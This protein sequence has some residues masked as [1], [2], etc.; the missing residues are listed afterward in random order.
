[1]KELYDFSKIINDKLHNFNTIKINLKEIDLLLTDE[2]ILYAYLLYK[3]YCWEPGLVPGIDLLN[4]NSFF[5]LKNYN[6][7][8]KMHEFNNT[9]NLNKNEEIYNSYGDKTIMDLLINYGYSE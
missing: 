8:K 5:N 2:E 1:M 7:N 9:N 4:A 6:Q 3:C